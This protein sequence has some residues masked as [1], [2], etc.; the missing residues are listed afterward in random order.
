MLGSALRKHCPPMFLLKAGMCV[1]FQS[2]TSS[3]GSIG[4]NKPPNLRHYHNDDFNLIKL[5][6]DKTASKVELMRLS[7]IAA[8]KSHCKQF[9]SLHYI[10]RR[11]DVNKMA[12]SETVSYYSTYYVRTNG[13]SRCFLFRD[14][15]KHFRISKQVGLYM[16]T[17]QQKSGRRFHNKYNSPANFIF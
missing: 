13:L 8:G 11:V 14:R 9:Y 5:P 4:N 17:Q 2:Q 10:A 15:P 3:A 1:D 6:I 12:V 16:V 7:R